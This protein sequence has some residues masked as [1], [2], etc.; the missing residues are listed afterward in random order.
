MCRFCFARVTLFF[1]LSESRDTPF[2]YLYSAREVVCDFVAAAAAAARQLRAHHESTEME[3]IEL[4]KIFF[5]I[6]VRTQCAMC[7][8]LFFLHRTQ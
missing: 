7:L 2:I 1:F 4:H 3:N 5:C 8:C 6:Y